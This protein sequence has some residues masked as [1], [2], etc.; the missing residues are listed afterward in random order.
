MKKWKLI[1][2]LVLMA[3]IAGAGYVF[4]LY[5]KKPA[6]IRKSAADYNVTAVAL[7]KEFNQNE[8]SANSKYMSK[9]IAV[10]GSIQDLK[11][12]PST[13][14][15]TVILNTGDPIAAITCSFYD[16]EAADLKN[17]KSGAVVI[18]KGQ[19]TG[20]LMDVVLNKCSIEK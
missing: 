7:M 17:L 18:V 4:Y 19:Y 5:K 2:L 15:A 8:T 10:K 16:T 12:D 14:H 20:K 6:D 9:V 13:G 11:I 1:T 3:G